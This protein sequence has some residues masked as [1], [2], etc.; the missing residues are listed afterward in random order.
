M[1]VWPLRFRETD[2]AIL[3]ADEAGGWFRASPG[4]LSR[5][6]EDQL[7]S[8]DRE[9]LLE[10][11]HASGSHGDLN[12]TSFLARWA[13]R[14]TGRAT[15]LN[16]LILVPTLR[17]DLACDYCQVSRAAIGAQGYDWD[18]SLLASVL[19]FLDSLSTEQIKIEF[20]GGEP[21]LR[22][23]LLIQVRDFCRRRFKKSQFVVCS[24]FQSVSDEAW[25][26]FSDEDTALSTSFD[27]TQDV[28]TQQRTHDRSKTEQLEQNLRSFVARF[29]A[30]RI[31]ALPTIDIEN[32]PDFADLLSS[33]HALGLNSI[34]LRPINRQGFARRGANQPDAAEKWRA[35]HNRFVDLLVDRNFDSEICFEE[36][37]LTHAL[38]R[39]LTPGMDGNVD[40]RNPNLVGTDYAVV[41][42]DGTLYPTDEA[43][44]MARVGQIDLSI[45]H[46]TSGITSHVTEL[47]NASGF[48][49]LDPDCMHCPYQPFCGT[50]NVDS[51]S[52]YGRIDLPRQQTWFCQRH[53][54]L[55]DKVFELLSSNDPKVIFSLQKWTGLNYWPTH[56]RE[57]WS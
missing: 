7:T 21:L 19:K 16:Y 26:F 37:Y 35:L 23:D 13:R 54:S 15:Q 46:V 24:N 43:R 49:D 17:C 56:F 51:I 33:F 57:V 31:S 25:Q 38:R 2:G 53:L 20:Q 47:L 3:F 10:N 42:Y 32:P 55:F 9:F 5:Y 29:G 28:H 50:D 11:G 8:G 22:L 18:E 27:G 4:F 44:M 52:R 41:D 45:G 36:Y 34:F 48:N 6:V 12:E 30:T 40:L 39:V 14:R 1:Q